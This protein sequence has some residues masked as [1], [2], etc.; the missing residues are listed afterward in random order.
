MCLHFR[1]S[2]HI[3]L[4]PKRIKPSAFLPPPMPNRRFTPTSARWW[5]RPALPSLVVLMW[6]RCIPIFRLGGILLNSSRKVLAGQN[7]ANKCSSSL[8]AAL[9]RIWQR[10]FIDQ[11]QA[12]AAVLCAVR[13]ANRSDGVWLI[14][15]FAIG[16]PYKSPLQPQLVALCFLLGIKKSDERSFYEIEAISQN[17]TNGW[18]GQPLSDV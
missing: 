4:R 2:E 15:N 9:L 18:S 16:E 13:A 11:S 1:K 14:S 12:D 5:R 17:C 10:F 6:C 8:Q 7:M 3:C